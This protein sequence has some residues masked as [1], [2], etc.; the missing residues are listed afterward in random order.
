M[1]ETTR[2]WASLPRD[3][4]LEIVVRLPQLDILQGAGLVCAPWRRV[5]SD[6]PTL[7]RS[8]HLTLDDEE[9]VHD[10]D[11]LFRRLAMARTAVRGPQ[12]RRLHVLPRPPRPAP[13]RLPC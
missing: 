7:W 8:I 5:A 13:P 4:L 12:R 6:E 3:V 2:D 10:L 1:E 9:R 11:L